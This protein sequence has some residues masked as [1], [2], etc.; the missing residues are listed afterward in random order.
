ME[1]FESRLKKAVEYV[2]FQRKMRIDMGL[3]ISNASTLHEVDRT[4]LAQKMA[5]LAAEAKAK[6]IKDKADA[7]AARFAKWQAIDD[8]RYGNN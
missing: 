4:A 2:K 7:K 1:E 3:A 5:K 6:R 8:K